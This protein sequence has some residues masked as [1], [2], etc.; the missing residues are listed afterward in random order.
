MRIEPPPSLACASGTMRAATA[1]AD[2]ALCR[3][4][5][6][7]PELDGFRRRSILCRQLRKLLMFLIEFC[8]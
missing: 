1:A 5:H 4:K 3:G 2:P 7:S 8:R 6:D